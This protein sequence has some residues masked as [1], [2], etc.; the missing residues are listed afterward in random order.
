MLDAM[1]FGTRLRYAVAPLWLNATAVPAYL[2]VYVPVGKIQL[3][4]D[5][6]PAEIALDRPVNWTFTVQG[7]GISMEGMSKLLAGM[8]GNDGLRLYPPAISIADNERPI[9]ASQTLR[10]TLP[11]VPLQTGKLE[12]PEINLPYY[13]PASARVE[14]VLI[15]ATS[16][17]VFNPLWQTAQKI[18]LGLL[19]LLGVIALAFGLIQHMRKALT[20]RK[21]LLAVSRAASAEELQQAL[22]KFDAASFVFTSPTLQQWLQRMQEIYALDQRLAVV[23]QKLESELYGAD[24]ADQA[25]AELAHEAFQLLRKLSPKKPAGIKVPV[26]RIVKP[27]QF[28]RAA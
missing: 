4:M 19:L 21:S 10:V 2:P 22:L 12:L 3:T 20:R 5:P 8:R 1:K 27:T 28:R 9:S 6:L 17:I 26:A 7:S 25:I 18:A 14:S 16:V 23:V 11:F 13:D 24:A 15:P